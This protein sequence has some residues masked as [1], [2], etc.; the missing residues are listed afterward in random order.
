MSNRYS[1]TGF[2]ARQ[3]ETL[4]KCRS[5]MLDILSDRTGKND[6]PRSFQQLLSASDRILFS[7]EEAKK[8]KNQD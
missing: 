8:W 4:E 7:I 2:T 3:V 6:S 5:K 1:N